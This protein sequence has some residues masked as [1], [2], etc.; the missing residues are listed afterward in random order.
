MKTSKRNLAGMM[1]THVTTKT[2]SETDF[3]YSADCRI[4]GQ[5]LLKTSQLPDFNTCS[6]RLIS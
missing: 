3:S 5:R 1:M 4:W 2:V 6:A